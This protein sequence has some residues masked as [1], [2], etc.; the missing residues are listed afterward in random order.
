MPNRDSTGGRS[1]RKCTQCGVEKD[2]SEFFKD[3]TRRS[4]KIRLMTCCKVCNMAKSSSRR[5]AASKLFGPG[6]TQDLIKSN[7]PAEGTPCN[8][9]GNPM[10]YARGH[11]LMC[12]DHDPN[13]HKFRGWLCQRCN[14]GLGMLGDTQDSLLN[15]LK[16]LSNDRSTHRR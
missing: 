2:H 12:F 7:R 13:T 8:L 5:K 9:C 1:T 15:A 16:Y 4:G 11:N 10:S 14:V 6:R 3:N